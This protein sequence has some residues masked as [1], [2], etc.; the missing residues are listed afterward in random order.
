MESK[1]EPLH[2]AA[3]EVDGGLQG[4]NGLGVVGGIQ[5]LQ[6]LVVV[7]EVRLVVLLVVQLHDVGADD[8]LQR[9]VVVVQVRQA[10]GVQRGGRHGPALRPIL[11]DG[12]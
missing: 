7:G 1:W 2:T 4:D 6:R 8:G 9:A 12:P 11:H 10:L 5:L 3:I